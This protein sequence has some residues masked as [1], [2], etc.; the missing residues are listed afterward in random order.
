MVFNNFEDDGLVLGELSF[1]I[2]PKDY[3]YGLFIK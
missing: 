1:S 2:E 3:P